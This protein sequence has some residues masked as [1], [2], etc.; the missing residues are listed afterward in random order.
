MWRTTCI[1]RS[2]TWFAAKTMPNFL[3][4]TTIRIGVLAAGLCATGWAAGP[5]AATPAA[6]L[7]AFEGGL[8][9]NDLADEGYRVTRM[10]R[11]VVLGTRWASVERCGHPEMPGLTLQASGVGTTAERTEQTRVANAAV[12]I[13]GPKVIRPGETVRLWRQE[14]NVRMEMAAVSD[15]SGAAGDRIRMR[16]TVQGESG[17]D[18]VR[19]VYGLVRGPADVEME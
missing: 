14:T 15:E 8:V 6:A 9:S 3:L 4:P 13:A 7:K 10:H 17:V 16:V 19:Y 2:T 18:N 1:R 5:C 12:R 11:D